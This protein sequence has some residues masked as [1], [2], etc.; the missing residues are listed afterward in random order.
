MGKR[1]YFS[2]IPEDSNKRIL[3]IWKDKMIAAGKKRDIPSYIYSAVQHFLDT[4]ECSNIGKL[5]ITEDEVRNCTEP[6]KVMLSL[7]KQPDI[8]D[9]LDNLSQKG[10]SKVNALSIIL[11]NSITRC[12]S[13]EE[14]WLPNSPSSTLTLDTLRS[15][16]KESGN[17][18]ST[19]PTQSQKKNNTEYS[20]KKQP[21]VDIPNQNHKHTPIKLDKRSAL[22]GKTMHHTS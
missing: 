5:Y 13:P 4:G 10:Y 1:Y 9:Y 17:T 18:G 16:R 6:L 15:L 22:M 11:A 8:S 2:V 19:S 21:Q 7:T 14:E 3:C 20:T 12:D